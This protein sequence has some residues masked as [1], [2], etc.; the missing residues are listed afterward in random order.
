MA[1][2]SVLFRQSHPSAANSIVFLAAMYCNSLLSDHRRVWMRCEYSVLMGIGTTFTSGAKPTWW[3]LG[4]DSGGS[5]DLCPCCSWSS[6]WYFRGI[7]KGFTVGLDGAFPEASGFRSTIPNR[8]NKRDRISR[9]LSLELPWMRIRC[10][11]PVVAKPLDTATCACSL[12]I[13]AYVTGR[14]RGGDA[15][16]W[17]DLFDFFGVKRERR[18]RKQLD[19]WLRCCDVVLCLSKKS[20]VLCHSIVYSFI[21]VVCL[22]HVPKVRCQVRASSHFIFCPPYV[23]RTEC[24]LY[25]H[26]E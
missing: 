20:S 22:V 10:V 7:W 3:T 25:T 21:C 17:D 13:S 23:R 5:L 2:S 24:L 16:L 9:P 12:L 4:M 14:M 6:C 1:S 19:G 8:C 15:I 18:C 11:E 26:S